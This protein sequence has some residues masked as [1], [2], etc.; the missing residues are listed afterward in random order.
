MK[1]RKKGKVKR[2]RIPFGLEVTNL[3]PKGFEE[4]LRSTGEHR[5]T[6]TP[7]K[8]EAPVFGNDWWNG[9][10]KEPEPVNQ[11]KPKASETATL[12]LIFIVAAGVIILSALVKKALG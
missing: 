1:K 8:K 2:R 5:V 11:T 9:E 10:D 7:D 12:T 6:K 4:H 3:R